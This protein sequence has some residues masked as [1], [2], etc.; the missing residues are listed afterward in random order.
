MPRDD[1]IKEA[2]RGLEKRF[3][4]ISVVLEILCGQFRR[5]AREFE[6]LRAELANLEAGGRRAEDGGQ[7]AAAV[8]LRPEALE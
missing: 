3:G 4:E 1:E 2:I 6:W 8:G 7:G 5:Q